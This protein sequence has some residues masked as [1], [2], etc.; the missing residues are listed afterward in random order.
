MLKV[1]LSK[2]FWWLDQNEEPR[3]LS[4][5]T[6]WVLNVKNSSA[7]N[8]T[9]DSVKIESNWQNYY[10]LLPDTFSI[11]ANTQVNVL[12]WSNYNLSATGAWILHPDIK[13]AKS[14][15]IYGN[16]SRNTEVKVYMAPIDSPDQNTPEYVYKWV[17][18]QSWA[19]IAKDWASTVTN[20]PSCSRIMPI[21]ANALKFY[22]RNADVSLSEDNLKLYI[23]LIF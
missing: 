4:V 13:R 18:E 22:L 20:S 3:A 19:F 7:L 15:Q 5:W 23:R 11:A 2:V 1:L 6:D 14:I 9:T 17:T 8:T 12:W 16:F 21:S 10:D